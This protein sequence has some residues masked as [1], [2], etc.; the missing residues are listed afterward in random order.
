MVGKLY[1][2]ISYV[3]NRANAATLAISL[4]LN[5]ASWAWLL[6]NIGPELDPV[7]LHYNVLFGIDLIGKWYQVLYVPLTGLVIFIANGIAAW[8]LFSK[9]SFASHMLNTVSLICQILLFVAG[10]LLVF[11][12]V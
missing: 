12:N 2:F 9:D 5:I 11:I 1:P 4:L 7:F 6:M 8:F 3:K 10:L